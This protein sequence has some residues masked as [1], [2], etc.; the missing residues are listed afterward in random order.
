MHIENMDKNSDIFTYHSE[1]AHIVLVSCCPDFFS[2]CGVVESRSRQFNKIQ[3]QSGPIKS[4][5]SKNTRLISS[6]NN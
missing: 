4:I 2:F 6:H 5:V 1:Y 3:N